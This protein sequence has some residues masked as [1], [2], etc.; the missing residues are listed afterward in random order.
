MFTDERSRRVIFVAHCVLNQNTKIDKCARYPGAM[1]EMA[2]ALV[3]SG[4]GIVQMPCPEM[5]HLGL[6]R[7]ADPRAARTV[8]SEDT[9][10]AERMN[11]PEAVELCGRLAAG[12]VEQIDEY[13]RHGFEVAGIVG[14]NGSPTCGVETGWRDDV[15]CHGPGVFLQAIRERGANVLMRGVKASEPEHAVALVRELTRS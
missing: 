15:E 13:R 6:D 8:E 12:V 10:V 9:R 2:M 4:V 3:A 11:Q 5:I 14:V 1:R 7:E